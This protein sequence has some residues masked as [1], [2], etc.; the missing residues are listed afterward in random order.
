[1]D[2]DD[3]LIVRFTSREQLR[4]N[5]MYIPSLIVRQEIE[6]FIHLNQFSLCVVSLRKRW[7]LSFLIE[8]CETFKNQMCDHIYIYILF[9]IYIKNSD[10]P[11]VALIRIRYNSIV[12]MRKNMQRIFRIFSFFFFSLDKRAISPFPVFRLSLLHILTYSDI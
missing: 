6:T 7:S 2:L 10:R 8:Y 11:S 3:R 4:E 9:L 1:M 12:A 5:L